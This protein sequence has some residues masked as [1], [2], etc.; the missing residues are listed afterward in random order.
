MQL[1]HFVVGQLAVLADVPDRRD[2][3]VARGI[4]EL[5]QQ[6]DRVRAAVQDEPLCVVT[7][8]RCVAEDAAAVL[9]GRLDVLE[10]PRRPQ[11]FHVAEPR[12]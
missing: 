10:P 5:V 2:H 6:R 8:R 9:V 7:A 4:R 3:E 1:E 11:A 12:L